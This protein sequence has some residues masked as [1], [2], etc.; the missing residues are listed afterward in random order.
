[1][2]VPAFVKIA[3]KTS[4]AREQM[5]AGTRFLN[6]AISD[7]LTAKDLLGCLAIAFDMKWSTWSLVRLHGVYNRR[8]LIEERIQLQGY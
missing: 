1:M 2:R 4:K 7:E 3:V 6:K 8:R 5:E